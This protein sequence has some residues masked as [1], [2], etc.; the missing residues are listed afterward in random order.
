MKTTA[1]TRYERISMYVSIVAVVISLGSPI[2]MYYWLDPTLKAFSLRGRL[3]VSS[4]PEDAELRKKLINS[5][6]THESPTPVIH[7][8]VEVLNIGQLPA[9]GIQIVAQYFSD[10]KEGEVTFEP[11]AQFEIGCHGTQK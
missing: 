4:S 6:L 1:M 9:N 11:P 7:F 2:L 3:Q 8:D 5:I 10:P